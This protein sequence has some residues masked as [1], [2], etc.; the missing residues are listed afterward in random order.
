MNTQNRI[1][2]ACFIGAGIGALL[3]LQFAHY[4]WWLGILI[5]GAVGYLSYEIKTVLKS[6]R[7]AVD[8]ARKEQKNPGKLRETGNN[9]WQ[10]LTKFLFPV[11]LFC[12]LL[13]VGWLGTMVFVIWKLGGGLPQYPDG[14]RFSDEAGRSITVG[15]IILFIYGICTSRKEVGKIDGTIWQGMASFF[16]R[17]NPLTVLFYWLPKGII[18]SVPF[19]YSVMKKLFVLIH[20]EIRLLY[21]TD[22]LIGASIGYFCGSA[23]IGGIAGAVCG[24]LNYKLISVRLLKLAPQ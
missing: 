1:V 18:W 10:I 4:L 6:I 24:I 9:I 15:L 12:F 11:L 17:M 22:S 14:I 13:G 21:L 3:A 7:T 20:S 5:G 23:L 2:L 16:V 8:A 19:L